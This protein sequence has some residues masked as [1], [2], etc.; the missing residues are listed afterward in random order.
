M[1]IGDAPQGFRDREAA[2]RIV[3]GGSIVEMVGGGAAIVLGILGLAGV[4]PRILAAI[5]TIAAGVGLLS[6]GSALAARYSEILNGEY[7]GG[8]RVSFGGWITS[9]VLGGGAAVVLGILALLG[10]APVTLMAVAALV[11]G[12]TLMMSSGSMPRLNSYQMESRGGV[13]ENIRTVTREALYAA[14]GTQ[15]LIGAAVLVL[16]ILVLRGID[17]LPLVLISML[18]AGAASLLSG[19]ALTARFGTRSRVRG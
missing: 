10:L 3:E 14:T 5:A 9:E 15:L 4:F 2:T 8:E 13:T 18:A 1:S 17:P 12:A 7:A 6:V 19:S 16:G 11:L